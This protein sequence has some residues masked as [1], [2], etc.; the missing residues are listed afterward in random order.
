MSDTSNSLF[1]YCRS[2]AQPR[3]TTTPFYVI[4]LSGLPHNDYHS[5]VYKI[6]AEIWGTEIEI[7]TLAHVLQTCVFI[8]STDD[9]NW[10]RYSPCCVDR[11][12]NDD[13]QH[14]PNHFDVVRS[15]QQPH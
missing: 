9:L 11:T 4:S 7:F 6:R 15:I 2:C 3:L 13:I 12:L 10:H 14:P 8:Y 5:L 1:C